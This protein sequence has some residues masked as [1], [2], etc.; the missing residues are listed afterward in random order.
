MTCEDCLYKGFCENQYGDTDY[1]DDEYIMADVEKLCGKFKDKSKIIELPC[2]VG[3]TVYRVCRRADGRKNGYIRK[4]EVTHTNMFWI[5]HG[6][7][8][9]DYYRTKEEARQ[10]LE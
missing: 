10:A 2:K 6:L 8:N 1:F 4:V 3:D 5:G 7:K 9:G